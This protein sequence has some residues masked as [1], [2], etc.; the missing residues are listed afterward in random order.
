MG[1]GEKVAVR[2]ALLYPSI[3]RDVG[4]EVME[5]VVDDL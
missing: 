5:R 2:C 4:F 3:G 1:V